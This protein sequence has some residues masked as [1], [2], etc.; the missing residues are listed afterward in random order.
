[1]R[2]KHSVYVIELDRDVLYELKFKKSNKQY[3]EGMPCVYVGMTGLDPDQ[4]FDNHK[5]GIKSNKYAKKYGLRLMTEEFE[6]INPM[7]YGDA[8]YMEVDLAIRLREKGYA[9]WQ[10]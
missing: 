6:G 2:S 1:M 8:Q 5:A 7:P 10:A 9:V 4:R 3:I